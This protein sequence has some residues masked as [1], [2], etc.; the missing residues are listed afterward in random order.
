VGR[1]RILCM[2]RQP[3]VLILWELA[4]YDIASLDPQ[5]RM[6]CAIYGGGFVVG[7]TLLRLFTRDN[8]LEGK[9][10]KWRIPGPHRYRR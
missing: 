6:L 10:R 2:V 1:Q 9:V 4:R 7:L 8:F 3:A 5:Q